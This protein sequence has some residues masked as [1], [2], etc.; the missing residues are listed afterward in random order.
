MSCIDFKVHSTA[1]QY[2]S[3]YQLID[4]TGLIF[5]ICYFA[6]C[7]LRLDYMSWNLTVF[8][9]GC[10]FVLFLTLISNLV[11]RSS[12]QSEACMSSV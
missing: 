2:I 5:S 1:C 3:L 11:R 4:L 7:L 10:R 12:V 8:F 9:R 6:F